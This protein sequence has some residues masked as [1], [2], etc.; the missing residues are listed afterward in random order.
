MKYRAECIECLVKRQMKRVQNEKDAEKAKKYMKRVLSAVIEAPEDVGA[1]YLI[2]RFNRIYKEMFTEKDEYREIKESS[3]KYVSAKLKEAAEKVENAEDSILAALKFARVGNYID[4]GALHGNVKNEVFDELLQKA[5]Q[6]S[7]DEKEYGIFR[8][9]L[10]KAGELLYI[11]DNAGEIVLDKLFIT[12]L[13]KRF[14]KLKIT[15][16]VRGA[17]VLNDATMEDAESIGLHGV[18]EVIDTG[19][20]I[21]GVYIPECGEKMKKAMDSADLIISK[22]QGNFEMMSGCGLNIY[23]V[24]LCKCE[25]FTRL[26]SLEQFTGVFINEKRLGEM[27]NF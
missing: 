16:A 23:Y 17:P 22:G 25:L 27:K 5:E 19:S 3:N 10:E 11:T 12:T 20:D 2:S 18:A 13:K 6:E 14:P 24:F 26:F 21:S 15:V 7:V 1:P 9:E 8:K 4:F